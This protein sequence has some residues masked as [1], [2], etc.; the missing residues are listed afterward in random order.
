MK[1][2]LCSV[3][4][5]ALALLCAGCGSDPA[6][7]QSAPAVSSVPAAS[8]EPAP[9]AEPAPE[10]FASDEQVNSFIAAY[11]A[12]AEYP[13]TAEIKEGNIKTKALVYDDLYDL[14]IVNA[15]DSWL[16][17]TLELKDA[18]NKDTALRAMFR[19]LLKAG[20]NALTEDAIATAWNDTCGQKWVENYEFGKF[21]ISYSDSSTRVKIDY[22]YA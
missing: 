2:V 19:D 3:L 8:S 4:A 7:A 15:Q 21:T 20:D 14:E 13:I 9:S 17:I 12:L 11:N 16:A 1:R 18:A 6:P 10:Y 22:H 5:C